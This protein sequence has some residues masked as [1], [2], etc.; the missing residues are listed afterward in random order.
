MKKFG[1]IILAILICQTA[2]IIGSFFTTPAI[3]GW[4]ASLQKPFFNP[5]GFVFGP[6]WLTLYTM[7]GISLYL[8][9]EHRQKHPLAP[10]AIILFLVHLIF[11]AAWSVVFFGAQQIL[12]ALF[13]IVLLV[14]M[15][16]ILTWQF[17]QIKKPAGYLL[18]PYLT[19]VLF[20]T[21][22]NFSLWLLN[23]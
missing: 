23:K 4:Y 12:L 16:S 20:A 18:M 22:L 21:I 19:W 10:N 15:I 3:P 17:W 9:W 5:P 14:C 8:V 2:G 7:M 1:K 11:N 6:V 13:I